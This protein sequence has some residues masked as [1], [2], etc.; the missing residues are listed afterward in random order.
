V[1]NDG[2][3]STVDKE[4]SVDARLSVARCKPRTESSLET[5]TW[6]ETEPQA[7]AERIPVTVISGSEETTIEVDRG[8]NLRKALLERE[9]PV[10]GTVSQYANCGGRGLCATCTV[11][12]DPPRSQLTGTTPSPSGSATPA[13]CIEVD[14][15]ITVRLLD[16]HVWGQVLPRQRSASNAT[17]QPLVDALTRRRTG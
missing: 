3:V 12:V 2:A 15:P 10:Y 5:A 1:R 9:F 4:L 7:M 11:E 8:T 14:E 17:S 13:C 6:H 16:K